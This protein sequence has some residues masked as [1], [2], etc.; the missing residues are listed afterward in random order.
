MFEAGGARG[1][2]QTVEKPGQALGGVRPLKARKPP[3]LLHPR[4]PPL[5]PDPLD[6]PSPPVRRR[7][8]KLPTQ[9]PCGFQAVDADV[10]RHF[11]AAP[12]PKR[13]ILP[14]R[15][16]R[17]HEL[18]ALKAHRMLHRIN[19]P[20]SPLAGWLTLFPHCAL[21]NHLPPHRNDAGNLRAAWHRNNARRRRAP[22]LG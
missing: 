15:P 5:Q 8:I 19:P 21:S 16:P 22:R 9:P 7:S 13:A 1:R 3:W 11:A 10:Q 18:L 6:L 20:H 12:N 14:S 4:E 2:G 17:R